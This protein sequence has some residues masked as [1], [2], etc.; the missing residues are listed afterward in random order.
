MTNS[1]KKKILRIFLKNTFDRPIQSFKKNKFIFLKNSPDFKSFNFGKKNKDKKFYVIRVYKSG[2]GLFSNLLYVLN[3][4]KVAGKLRLIPIVDM[5]NFYT[6][7]N[8]KNKI[9]GTKNSW[10]YY[11]KQVSK[12]SLEDVYESSNVTFSNSSMSF[13][14]NFIQNNN[15]KKI[16]KNNIKIKDFFLENVNRFKHKNFH[17]KKIIGVHLRGTDMRITPNHTMPPTPDQIFYILDKMLKLKK[18]DKIFLVTDQKK[19]LDKFKKKY[20]NLLCYTDCFRSDKNKIFDI[21]IRKNHRFKLGQE[22]LEQMLLLSKLK[23]IIS[24]KSNLSRCSMMISKNSIKSAELNNGMNS[25]K[26]LF[27]RVKWFIKDKLPESIFGFKKKLNIKFK[28][29]KY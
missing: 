24:S 23:Y 18:F 6:L 25:K 26:I 5:E 22:S 16:F 17:N 15:F 2:G 11:F 13:P 1:F 9:N 21:K 14:R 12:Y 27:A 3:H 10:L 20:K 7:Y 19:Y 4:L 8:E 28:I 29:I